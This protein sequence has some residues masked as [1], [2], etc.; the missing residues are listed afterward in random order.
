LRIFRVRFKQLVAKTASK[1]TYTV[2]RGA[3]KFYPLWSDCCAYVC[4]CS[5]GFGIDVIGYL[6]MKDPLQPFGPLCQIDYNDELLQQ[7]KWN[8]SFL[9]C[10]HGSCWHF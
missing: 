3:L 2:S 8:V 6:I 7:M 9:F 1:M 10:C 4:L 5:W